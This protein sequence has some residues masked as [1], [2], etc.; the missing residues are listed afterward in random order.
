M[1][2]ITSPGSPTRRIPKSPKNAATK[3][4]AT[5]TPPSTDHRRNSPKDRSFFWRFTGSSPHDCQYVDE[6]GMTLVD[7]ADVVD[8][9]AVRDDDREPPVRWVP[10]DLPH[11]GGVRLVHPPGQGPGPS[12]R[13][14]RTR[15]PVEVDPEADVVLSGKLRKVDWTPGVRPVVDGDLPLE[16]RNPHGEPTGIVAP[17]PEGDVPPA[18]NRGER[19]VLQGR[20]SEPEL[21]LGVVDEFHRGGDEHP[22]TDKAERRVANRNHPR[23]PVHGIPLRTVSCRSGTSRAASRAPRDRSGG[24]CRS[25]R[26]S[27]GTRTRGTP[28]ASPPRSGCR[29]ASAS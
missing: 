19:H 6:R 18:R 26:A 9:D 15:E 11:V 8:H 12:R 25:S 29:P 5:I 4:A 3:N 21:R 23:N 17:P 14:H 1:K 22:C 16:D 28:R 27:P 10:R 20:G 24:S 7:V 2:R 13:D